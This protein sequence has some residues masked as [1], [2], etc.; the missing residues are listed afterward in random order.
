MVS[1]SA[2]V[3][4]VHW[5]HLTWPPLFPPLMPFAFC[6]S[7]MPTALPMHSLAPTG[8]LR[9]TLTLLTI[10]VSPGPGKAQCRSLKTPVG[11]EARADQDAQ[12]GDHTQQVHSGCDGIHDTACVL[13]APCAR[14]VLDPFSNV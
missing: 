7:G 5:S 1:G 10:I 3:S 9:V 13:H 4:H 6:Q 12:Q 11:S 8:L 14:H 2:D